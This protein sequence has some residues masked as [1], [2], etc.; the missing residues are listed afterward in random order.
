MTHLIAEYALSGAVG[1]EYR[2]PRCGSV[3]WPFPRHHL[4][5]S[6]QEGYLSG[7]PASGHVSRQAAIVPSD[8]AL[9][10]CLR[11]AKPLKSAK[12]NLTLAAYSASQVLGALANRKGPFDSLAIKVLDR[13]TCVEKP[14]R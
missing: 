4:H 2:S 9:R 14:N 13:R 3:N 10:R 11:R 6:S 5:S 8:A 12:L 1:K 7:R